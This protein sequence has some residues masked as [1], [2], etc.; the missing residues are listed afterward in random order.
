MEL[1]HIWVVMFLAKVLEQRAV[2]LSLGSQK[3][4]AKE[5]VPKLCKPP[6]RTFGIKLLRIYL[7]ESV[8]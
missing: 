6:T 3:L 1:V 2:C 8:F 7:L 5:K 4:V